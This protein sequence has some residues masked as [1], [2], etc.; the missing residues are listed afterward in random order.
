MAFLSGPRQVGKTTLA[1]TLAGDRVINWDD[2]DE[3]R[4]LLAGPGEVAHRFGL[5]AL[6]AA[7]PVVG[8]D[9]IHKFGRWKSFLKGFF[10]SYGDRA[11]VLVTGSS[12][13][14]VFQ[15]G[16]DSLMGRYL[17]YRLH[18]FSVG[19]LAR[20]DLPDTPVRPPGPVPDAEYLALLEHG[21]YPE[22]F[23]RRD[24]RFTLR[25][26]DLRLQQ[27][28]REDVRDLTRVRELGQLEV[29]A[30]LLVERS[31]TQLVLSNLA[32]DVQTS[33]DT[34]RRWVETLRSLHLGFVVRPWFR[35]VARSLRKEP[36]WF[37]SDWS[38]VEDPGARAETLVACHL[39]K[40]VDAW[41]DLGFGRFE[42]HYLRDK[43]QREVDF[44]V[45]KD[46]EPWFLAEVKSAVE[47]VSPALAY[48]QAQTR[49]PHAFQVTLD[50]DSVNADCFNHRQP[51]L[52]PARTFL[53]QLV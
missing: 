6:Q 12:C 32:L 27:L 42:L 48:F 37:L 34:V 16:G 2:A 22:P 10:D 30:R 53:S 8:F 46:R 52:V 18:P 47:R 13:L 33:V 40:A 24:R 5:E 17:P 31:A 35:N 26:G 15:R 21:G 11:R 49:A 28:L 45:V 19:E 29:L 41:N 39:Q 43:E 9:E 20:T 23:V 50:M 7:P 4:L 38:R 44:L 3:R 36:R 51:M 25:W 14:E 1:E